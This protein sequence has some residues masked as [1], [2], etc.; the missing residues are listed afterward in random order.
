MLQGIQNWVREQRYCHRL[1]YSLS[2]CIQPSRKLTACT[3]PIMAVCVHSLCLTHPLLT[4]WLLMTLCAPPP[5][6][7]PRMMNPLLTRPSSVVLW[8]IH[9][10]YATF[11]IQSS[12]KNETKKHIE[13]E[14][15]TYPSSGCEKSLK[16]DG[17]RH[18]NEKIKNRI[19]VIDFSKP[20]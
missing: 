20:C 1:S 9:M 7:L 18:L 3:P 16:S 10:I 4:C 19:A 15:P 13:G 6:P 8:N 14:R 11:Y 12:R 17:R 2:L 5:R